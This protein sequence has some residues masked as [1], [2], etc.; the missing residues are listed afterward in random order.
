MLGSDNPTTWIVYNH[1]MLKY[2][3]FPI[4]IEPPVSRKAVFKN[5]IR[6]LGLWEVL[7]QVAFI[8]LI[9]PLLARRSAATVRAICLRH[10]LEPMAPLSPDILQVPSVNSP[11]CQAYLAE[12]APRVV[13][14]NGTRILKPET[15]KATPATFINTHQG[16]TPLYRGAHGGYWALHQGDPQH[17]GITIHLV[18]EGIDTGNIVSQRMIVPGPKDCFVTYPY[19]QTAAALPPLVEAIEQ[20]EAGTLATRPISGTS[21]IWYHPTLWTYLNGR[22]R[23]VR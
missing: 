12:A 14:V 16:I 21:R 9:R 15:L 13:V 8:V 10:G 22:R 11:T 3:S 7:G 6:K 18:D 19:L 5:R 1:L 20:A 2:G 4:L 17:C 23:G